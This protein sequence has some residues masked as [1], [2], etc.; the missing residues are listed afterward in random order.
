MPKLLRKGEFDW[1]RQAPGVPIADL[2]VR[3]EDRSHR[4]DPN[5]KAEQQGRQRSS[6]KD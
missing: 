5:A 6:S 3:I 4:S 2:K 1:I